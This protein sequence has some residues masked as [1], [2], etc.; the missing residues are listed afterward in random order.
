MWGQIPNLHNL[1]LFGFKSHVHILDTL[2][3]KLDPKTKDYIF[4]GYTEGVKVG[5]F[6]YV[7][8]S[9][10][11]VLRDV[12]VRSVRLNLEQIAGSSPRYEGKKSTSEVNPEPLKE[13]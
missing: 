7:A 1:L 2:R 12:V 13:D 10:R 8:T 5:V 6:E 11:L 3:G 4:L 9:E